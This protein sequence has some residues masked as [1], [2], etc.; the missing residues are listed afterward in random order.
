MTDDWTWPSQGIQATLGEGLG[1]EW[2][3][4]RNDVLKFTNSDC[5]VRL[6]LRV[7]IVNQ[8]ALIA[9]L[10]LLT[11][12]MLIS[13]SGAFHNAMATKAG[14]GQLSYDESRSVEKV[15]LSIFVALLSKSR[16]EQPALELPS[17]AYFCS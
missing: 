13:L 15:R 3:M 16:L 1:L 10:R 5:Q 6:V 11:W 2:P 7:V 4:E 17:Q 14:N 9:L 12:R 8:R